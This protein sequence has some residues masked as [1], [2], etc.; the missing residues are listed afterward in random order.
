MI[1]RKVLYFYEYA[2]EIRGKC[3]GHARIM[4]CGTLLKLTLAFSLPEWEKK[5]CK[6][7]FIAESGQ[8]HVSA[9]ELGEIMPCGIMTVYNLDLEENR[10]NGMK[11]GEIIHVCLFVKES[12]NRYIKAVMGVFDVTGKSLNAILGEGSGNANQQPADCGKTAEM[13]DYGKSLETDGCEKTV[14]SAGGEKPSETEKSKKTEDILNYGRTG[15]EE[16]T[17]IKEGKAGRQGENAGFN[18]RENENYRRDFGRERQAASVKGH[19]ERLM[20]TR[21]EYRPFNSGRISCSVRIGI[22]DVL[23]LSE[24]EP[25]LKDNSFLLH[26][27]YRYKH[28]LLAGAMFR[29]QISYYVLVPGVKVEREQKVADMYG[30]HNFITLDG[31]AP[32]NGN[33]GYYSWQLSS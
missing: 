26:G 15:Y 21:P 3:L 14:G 4:V 27:F 31:Q 10:L 1:N 28:I 8:G 7:Y 23:K 11:I 5:P 22:G 17:V 12:E 13:A 20:A 33:F 25:G 2:S 19:V 18:E 32:R 16:E 30:F 6:L 29:G 9:I 24:V